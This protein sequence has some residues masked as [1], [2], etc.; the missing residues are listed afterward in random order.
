[1]RTLA[2]KRAR[3]RGRW[4]VCSPRTT[5]YGVTV[6]R[7]LQEQWGPLP[8]VFSEACLRVPTNFECYPVTLRL[9]L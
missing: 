6:D 7:A 5:P 9:P 3:T 1:M 8:G 2:S 4:A